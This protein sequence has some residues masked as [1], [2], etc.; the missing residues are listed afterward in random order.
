MSEEGI[1]EA[2]LTEQ[3]RP[4]KVKQLEEKI[5]KLEKENKKLLH[6]V[7]ALVWPPT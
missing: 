3:R 6:K 4:T 5:K 1:L 7:T 2:D